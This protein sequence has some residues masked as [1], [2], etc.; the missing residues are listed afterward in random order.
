MTKR[1]E[2]A[3]AAAKAD[4]RDVDNIDWALPS[5]AAQH[6]FGVV[7]AIL[8]VLETPTDQMVRAGEH[9]WQ[10][11]REFAQIGTTPR[12]TKASFTA[13]IRAIRDE[14]TERP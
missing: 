1:E 9:G 12:C 2:M 14:A 5:D 4:W 6:W 11:A 10:S 8:A 7:D 13:M 3:R